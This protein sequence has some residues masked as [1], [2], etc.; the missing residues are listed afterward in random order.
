[1]DTPLLVDD[2][3]GTPGSK[4]KEQKA[5]ER[6][7]GEVYFSSYRGILETCEENLNIRRDWWSRIVG[8]DPAEWGAHS[9]P[10]L[11]GI[12]PEELANAIEGC[13]FPVHA[14][15][16]NWLQSNR[17]SAVLLSER[18]EKLIEKYRSQKYR[19]E[20]VIIVTHS[21]GGLLARALVH[22]EM[23]GLQDQVLG[24]VHGV[25]PATGAPAAYKRMRCGFEESLGGADPAPKV[26]GNY[27]SEVTAVLGNS[28]GGLELLP[29]CNYGNGWLEIR[30]NG[31]LLKSLPE[32]GDPYAEIY[33]VRDN[34]FK[35]LREEWLNP[36]K[37]RGCGFAYTAELLKDARAFHEAIKATYHPN[38]YAHYGADS[39]RA[40]W[41]RVVWVVSPSCPA[42]GWQSLRIFSDD[43]KGR[44]K[45]FR[46]GEDTS[47]D[48][49]SNDVYS[50]DGVVVSQAV[51]PPTYEVVLGPASGAGDQTVPVRSADSQL[52][53]GKFKGVFRQIGYEHQAS[54][55]NAAA[56]NSTIFAIVRIALEMKWGDNEK[57]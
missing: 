4:T 53:S 1:V 52:F 9:Q 36:A 29:S 47:E 18:V 16:Y 44:F 49:V 30:K 37:L 28:Q 55:S 27:G 7:W 23:G 45:I 38:S 57:K 25:M 21:M 43:Y 42:A 17:E 35:L 24:V 12:S 39:K 11:N 8:V 15:G 33:L 40:S 56:I 48:Q 31:V 5:M 54:Y 14:M 32:K 51:Q 10:R 46:S 34:W 6:G 22:P 41:E 2:I 26:L 50:M 20:K 13:W 19:C 3:A